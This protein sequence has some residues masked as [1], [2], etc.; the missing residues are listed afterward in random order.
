M[1][2]TAL[3][4]NSIRA[5]YLVLQ[6]V[7]RQTSLPEALRA[8]ASAACIGYPSLAEVRLGLWTLQ[9]AD[10][11]AWID[12]LSRARQV[13]DLLLALDADADIRDLARWGD[14]HFPTTAQLAGIRVVRDA[15]RG[16]TLE[17]AE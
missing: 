13:L 6:E 12:A 17:L 3:G 5:T 8:A 15:S 7:R 10:A 4:R 16:W 9:P 11:V 2:I 14:R 1:R